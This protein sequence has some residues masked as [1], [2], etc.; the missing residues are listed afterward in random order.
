MCRKT[1]LVFHIHTHIATATTSCDLLKL[2]YTFVTKSV[3][4][5]VGML[6]V[7]VRACVW[8]RACVVALTICTW[9]QT[10]GFENVALSMWL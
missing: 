9:H 5:L 8:L 4:L 1:Q 6:C 2:H 10:C 7:G 3:C